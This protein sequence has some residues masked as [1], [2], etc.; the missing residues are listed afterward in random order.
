MSQ[1][2]QEQKQSSIMQKGWLL[3]NI[4][5][6]ITESSVVCHVGRYWENIDDVRAIKKF[7]RSI[8][9]RSDHVVVAIEKSKDLKTWYGGIYGFSTSARVEEWKK[10][11]RKITRTSIA[12]KTEFEGNYWV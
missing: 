9:S 8:N 2:Q 7:L 1:N 10:E 4:E 3:K 12:S 6:E 5:R 11:R